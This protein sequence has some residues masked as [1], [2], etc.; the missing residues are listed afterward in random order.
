MAGFNNTWIDAG[1][2]NEA[3]YSNM[4]AGNYTFKVKML[5]NDSDNIIAEKSK[6]ESI[7]PEPWNS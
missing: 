4:T 6:Q 5:G 1:N 3:Y 2:N 7:T